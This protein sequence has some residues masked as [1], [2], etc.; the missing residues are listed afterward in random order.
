M[1]RLRC[2]IRK[3]APLSSAARVCVIGLALLCTTG[4]ASK[5]ASYDAPYRVAAPQ[6][7]IKVEIE[8]DGLP[9][10][11]APR[12]AR[13]GP[14]DPSQPWSPNYGKGT[15]SRQA[16]TAAPSAPATP[17]PAAGPAARPSSKRAATKL[18]EAAAS[19]PV[20]IATMDPDD[21]IRRAIAEHEMRRRD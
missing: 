6:D 17:A 8:D 20:Q 3:S 16:E 18:A 19:I 14:D 9:A 21:I 5:Q 15:A 11:I 1:S 7:Q 13:P 4:C 12:H 10:Q 2:S